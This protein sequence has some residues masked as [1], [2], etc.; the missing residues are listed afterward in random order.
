MQGWLSLSHSTMITHL[1][2]ARVLN[3]YL[4]HRIQPF[5]FPVLFFISLLP[6]SSLSVFSSHAHFPPYPL[7]LFQTLAPPTPGPSAHTMPLICSGGSEESG[8]CDCKSFVP[9]KSKKSKCKTCG[10]R[11]NLHSDPPTTNN[12]GQSKYVTHLV[13]SLDASAVHEVARKETLQGF[14]PVSPIVVSPLLP[15]LF[16]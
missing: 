9:K 12:K 14:R 1:D 16:N 11:L 15:L 10:H 6:T 7:S 5:S 2:N 8:D 4:T 13:H 3:Q